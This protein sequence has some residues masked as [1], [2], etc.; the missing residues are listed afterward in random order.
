MANRVGPNRREPHR[1]ARKRLLHKP[2]ELRRP[3]GLI[4]ETYTFF[5]TGTY[6]RPPS[7][8]RRCSRKG[9][10]TTAQPGSG[11]HRPF[12][13]ALVVDGH[14]AEPV[15]P[16]TGRERLHTEIATIG[17]LTGVAG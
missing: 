4:C 12:G 11:P 5:L 17:N 10:H 6:F 16:P 2:S 15:G 13:Q 3:F 9:A 7:P 14:Q 1:F 8:T